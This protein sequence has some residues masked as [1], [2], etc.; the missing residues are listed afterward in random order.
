[1]KIQVVIINRNLLTWPSK[2][3]EDLKTF[4]NIGDIIIVDNESTYEPLLE[5]YKTKPCE[6]VFSPVNYGQ[7]APWNLDLHKERNFYFYVVSDP[8]MDLSETPK[9]CLV[10]LVDKMEKHLEFDR[11]GLGLSNHKVPESSPYHHWLKSWVERTTEPNSIIDGLLTKQPVDTT[12][13]MYNIN[14]HFSGPSCSTQAPYTARHIPWEITKDEIHN[15]K[16]QNYEFY[17]YLKNATASA[18][19]KSFISFDK[20]HGK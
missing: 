17:Y 5:W 1:M 3:V 15:L 4:E 11:I 14:R 19:Y 2:M 7:S 18:S 10:H 12:F 9:D 6:V 16:E 13:C 8:D 20:I